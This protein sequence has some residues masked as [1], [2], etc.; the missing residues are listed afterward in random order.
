MNGIEGSQ[1]AMTM[2][3][4]FTMGVG[5]WVIWVSRSGRRKRRQGESPQIR[6]SFVY[7]QRAPFPF[8]SYPALNSP[9]TSNHHF[10]STQRVRQLSGMVKGEVGARAIP[11]GITHPPT[12]HKRWNRLD[13]TYYIDKS[14]Q[15]IWISFSKVLS[16]GITVLFLFACVKVG[17]CECM[18]ALVRGR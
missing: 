1:C 18:C 7:L 2:W 16:F 15:C 9:P 13:L 12:S 14:N 10:L 5:G 6:Q 8:T 17:M 11:M 4:I 3:C